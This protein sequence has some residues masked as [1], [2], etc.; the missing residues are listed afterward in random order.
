M[1]RGTPFLLSADWRKKTV[2]LTALL[3]AHCTNLAGFSP[4]IQYGNYDADG[5]PTYVGFARRGGATS[6]AVW[7]IFKLTFSSSNLQSVT[8]APLNSIWDNRTSLTY[9]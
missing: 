9:A 8:S 6:S 7:A 2:D 1:S 5:N 4:Q 3:L